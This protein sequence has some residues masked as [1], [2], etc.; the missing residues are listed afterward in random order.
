MKH[1]GLISKCFA[2]IKD[3]NKWVRNPAVIT[4]KYIDDGEIVY[5]EF[6]SGE[7]ARQAREYV[8][9]AKTD[10]ELLD[11]EVDRIIWTYTNLFPGCLIKS[12]EGIRLKKKYFW[13][14]TKVINRHWLA[15]NMNYEA[16]L[17]F[18]A[19][20]TKKITGQDVIDFIEFRRLQAEGAAFDAEFIAA[21]LGKPQK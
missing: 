1:L 21:V 4:D 2:V 17:G 20:N 7:E 13:D 8:K 15:V 11:A 3:N 6:K 18:N 10:F 12:V 19:F 16:H 14:Q 9:N 5:G